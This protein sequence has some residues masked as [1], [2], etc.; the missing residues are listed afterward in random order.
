MKR[1]SPPTHKAADRDRR[2]GG[3]ATPPEATTPETTASLIERVGL[4]ARVQSALRSS[5]HVDDIH[6]IILASL[7]SREGLGFSRAFLFGYDVVSG[8]L[9]GLAAMGATTQ[10]EHERLRGEAGLET[11]VL[12]QLT[13]EPPAH[14]RLAQEEAATLFEHGARDPS[15]E[16][17]WIATCQ[18]YA[19]ARKLAEATRLV[20][21]PFGEIEPINPSPAMRFLRQVLGKAAAQV[22]SP[23]WLRQAGLPSSLVDLLPGDS[24]WLA[25]RT[26]KGL[27]RV[28][29]A[30]KLFQNEPISPM[31]LLHMDWFAGQ[32]AMGL[33]IA[34]MYQDLERAYQDL[35]DLD[36]MKTN[37]LAVISHELRTPLTAI[38]GYLQLLMD[39]RVG[40]LSQGQCDV[41]KRVGEHSELLTGKVNDLIEIA[42]L[43]MGEDAAPPL[44]SVD[45]LGAIAAILPRVESRRARKRV[46]IEPMVDRSIPLIRANANRL[47]R[48]LFHLLDNAIKFGREGGRVRVE[49]AERD[50][51]LAISVSDDGIG[52]STDK[53]HSIFDAF[54]QVDSQLTR[55]YEGLGIGLTVIKRQLA[56][57]GGRIQAQSD[58]GKGST[59]TILYP[60]AQGTAQSLA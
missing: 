60:L 47:E 10:E 21:V 25:L 26:Q 44:E 52:I 56:L 11:R 4:I 13:R 53:M 42:E 16:S 5:L 23:Q 48:I 41:L 3:D 45:P 14:G 40:D 59:F 1:H 2:A 55:N 46:S 9:R 36:R 28:I 27:R 24:L 19:E 30:D 29:V 38:N 20:H 22:I 32:A 33:E 12:A 43:D 35:R 57:T 39:N 50:G 7:I 58:P 8:Q 54:Y 15:G 49:F 31:N 17:Y 34:E 18:V 37:F 6:S 51:E